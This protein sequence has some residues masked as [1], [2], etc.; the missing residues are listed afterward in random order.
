M[1]R[2]LIGEFESILWLGLR[3]VLTEKGCDVVAEATSANHM[4]DRMV[5][6]R[7][8]VVVID[9]DAEDGQELIGT[10]SQAYPSVTLIALSM[11]TP[12]MKVYPSSNHEESYVS[13]LNPGRLIQ[14][15]T[16][17]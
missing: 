11:A 6:A 2:V 13:E 4:M 14:A 9:M 5:E 12:A 17:H 10:I 1:R 3:E 8:D 15:V 7:A 16:E